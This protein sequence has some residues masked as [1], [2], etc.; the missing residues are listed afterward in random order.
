MVKLLE[1]DELNL[2]EAPD[3]I[4]HAPQYTMEEMARRC[5][6]H[7]AEWNQARY[8]RP[9]PEFVGEPFRLD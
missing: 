5:E 6:K 1:S 3:F 7:L 2:P 9:E 8:S 4:S